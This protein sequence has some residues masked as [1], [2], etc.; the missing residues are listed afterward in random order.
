MSPL[1]PQTLVRFDT[2][3][4]KSRQPVKVQAGKSVL[5]RTDIE[6]ISKRNKENFNLYLKK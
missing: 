3:T 5:R 2:Q 4:L 6:T 1:P